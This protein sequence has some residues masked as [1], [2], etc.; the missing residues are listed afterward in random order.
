MTTKYSFYSGKSKG[1]VIEVIDFVKTCKKLVFEIK[2]ICES[3][4]KGVKLRL[5][6]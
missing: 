5:K 6:S 1:S 4:L 3:Y 2:K